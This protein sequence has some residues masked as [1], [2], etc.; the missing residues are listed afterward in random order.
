MNN[1]N[2]QIVRQYINEIMPKIEQPPKGKILYP[3]LSVTYGAFYASAIYTWDFHHAAMR[4]A[5]GGKPEYLRFFVDNLL[6]YQQSDGHTPHVVNVDRGPRFLD[7][8]SH[9]Q[10]FLFQAAF[11]YVNQTGDTAWGNS[12]FDKLTKYVDFFDKTYSTA[13]GLLRWRTNWLGGLDNDVATVFLPPDSVA[14]CDISGWVHIELLAAEKLAKRLERAPEAEAFARRARNHR[15][16]VNDKLWYGDVN[17]YSAYNLSEGRP[18]FRY[19][20]DV[21]PPGVG[22][23]AFQTGT[24]LIPL[25]ARMAN[26]EAAQAMIKTYVVSEKHFW[27]PYGIRTLSRAS[28]YFNNAVWGNP[29]RFGDYRRM[30][31]SN[32]QGPVWIPLNYFT[33][34]ALRHYG[35][36]AEARTLADRSVD[37]LA[38]SLKVLGSF[39]ENFDSETGE[40]L[41]ASCYTSWNLLGDTMHDD[42]AGGNWI[43]DPIF[44]ET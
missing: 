11:I 24:N 25:Y 37:V 8:P 17:S 29:S 34:H 7:V 6:A 22:E 33:F 23:F 44:S 13:Y 1:P 20:F 41:Y 16:I 26:A 32:W 5:I 2:L 42:L 14:S 9:A 18:L 10:P 12:V 15:Q 4:F 28:E 36:T 39:S 43:M 27:S 38:N 19:T 40:P 35:F 21:L 31:E 30:T 3:W